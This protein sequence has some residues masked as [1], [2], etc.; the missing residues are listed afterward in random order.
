MSID[1]ETAVVTTRPVPLPV[2]RLHYVCCQS[3]KSP[4]PGVLC[5]WLLLS[6]S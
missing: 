1:D 6:N 4:A 3:M 2:C 5:P